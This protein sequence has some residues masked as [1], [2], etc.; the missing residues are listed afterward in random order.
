LENSVNRK[1]QKDR[2]G[3]TIE[4]GRLKSE[5]GRRNGRPGL[6]GQEW[7]FFLVEKDRG[8]GEARRGIDSSKK[9]RRD[10]LHPF[11]RP[12]STGWALEEKTAGGSKGGMFSG[13]NQIHD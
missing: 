10:S 12:R 2:R 8:K 11:P 5:G 6:G 7:G 1:T 9:G 13:G 3:G 4:V